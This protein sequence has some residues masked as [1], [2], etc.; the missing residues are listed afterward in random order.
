MDEKPVT[1]DP[2]EEMR[3]RLPLPHHLTVARY[4]G[5]MRELVQYRINDDLFHV[6]YDWIDPEGRQMTSN[7]EPFDASMDV[8]A[9]LEQCRAAL[10]EHR[11]ITQ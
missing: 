5:D 11:G 8:E 4:Q 6:R 3:R 2:I 7:P 9:Y 10:L 1:T